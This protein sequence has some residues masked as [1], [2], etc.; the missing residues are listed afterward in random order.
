MRK[1]LILFA[2]LLMLGA[3]CAERVPPPPPDETP[4]S[5]PENCE[6]SG[7]KIVEGF[8]SCPEGYAPDPADFCLDAEGVPGG[9]MSPEA[10]TAE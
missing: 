5:N 1:T 3:G 4:D 7:G 8:C 2:T 6:M 9:E 10:E